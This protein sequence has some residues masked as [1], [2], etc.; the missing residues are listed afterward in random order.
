MPSLTNT[1]ER[2][3]R[4]WGV[5]SLSAF[6]R[7]SAVV[8]AL[9]VLTACGLGMTSA[10]RLDRGQSAFADGD[11]RAAA[12][13]ARSVLQKEP[14]NLSARLLLGRSSL[15]LGDPESARKELERAV[16]LG[17]SRTDVML[18][19]AE[20]SL[21]L[22]DFPAAV[23]EV[24]VNLLTDDADR[25]RGHQ[26]RGD[27]S[28]G[29]GDSEAARAEFSAAL[30][31]DDE[32]P[33][34]MLGVVESYTTEGR[35][36]QARAT[37]EQIRGIHPNQVEVWLESGSLNLMYGTPSAAL[38]DFRQAT[39][40]A[41][42]QNNESA[43]LA[44]LMG[45]VES[46]LLLSN[47]EEAEGVLT[48]LESRVVDASTHL[49][50][51]RLEF[52]RQNWEAAQRSVQ[53]S[54]RIA[55]EFRPAQMLLG[56]THLNRGNL[57]QAE[58][59][60]SAVVAASPDDAD[61]R[62]LLAETQIQL[63]KHDLAN[64]ALRPLIAKGST[65]TRAL[66]AAARASLATGDFAAAQDFMQRRSAANPNDDALSLDL[67]ATYLATGD[68]REAEAL[69]ASIDAGSD[70]D[71]RRREYLLIMA[72]VRSGAYDDAEAAT[73]RL[74]DRWPEDAQFR[75]LLGGIQTSMGDSSAAGQTYQDVL[76]LEPGN[77]AA[78]MSLGDMELAA[79]NF[80]AA[81]G[82][83]ERA[84]AASD[85]SVAPMIALAKTA[86]GSGDAQATEEWLLRARAADPRDA[87]SRLYLGRYYL[88][89]NQLQQAEEVALEAAEIAPLNADVANLLGRVQMASG[90]L[91]E[92]VAALRQAS[93]AQPENSS[94]RFDYVRSLVAARRMDDA[95]SIL[96]ELD[97]ASDS[98]DLMSRVRLAVLRAESGDSEA[99]IREARAL[100]SRYPDN[101]MPWLL[102]G[103][104]LYNFGD[105]RYA[106]A[107][108]ANALAR[109]PDE[110]LAI[111]AY[112]LRQRHGVHDPEEPLRNLLQQRPD[113]TAARLALA[114]A[115]H[116]RSDLDAAIAEYE[117]VLADAPNN[118]VALN[119][120]A[121]AYFATGDGRAEDI[122]RRAFA[123]Y[124]DSDSIMDTLGWILTRSGKL[125]E[126]IGLLRQASEVSGGRGEVAYHLAYALSEQGNGAEAKRILEAALGS[127]ASFNSRDDAEALL[128]TL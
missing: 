54:L 33:E 46:L 16:E 39:G 95:R 91:D 74:V 28:L 26:L 86:G 97:A 4:T 41:D 127:D 90:K 102:E 100:Q 52:S 106:A 35:P 73:R 80:A 117:Q 48:Q 87:L 120:L 103:E 114:Q 81:R 36:D 62:R 21:L 27:A 78:R 10:E 96:D 93:A 49:L 84:L 15:R 18:D 37:L 126:G 82:H 101:P 109:R 110:R 67:A 6:R 76:N 59:Y 111:R 34:A 104:L 119:N 1:S 44:A 125:D 112:G 22:G 50:R 108:Y 85:S 123:E 2:T 60:L 105:A 24:D 14:D 51:G 5:A 40:L 43:E 65:D 25:V 17:Q 61:A 122:A 124:P 116:A 83:F 19:L 3:R 92:G 71:D 75:L 23:N 77:L 13:D 63:Q 68:V 89:T 31:I 20:A 69:L 88:S 58:M 107:A 47:L 29:L 128:A 70:F 66:A 12:I 9:L 53:E 45:Q 56:A 113:A 57:E 38:D 30:R 32:N 79:G 7:L 98:S 72:Q 11:H 42:S 115:F 64:D 99:G 118:V 55:P 8:P 94:F 121:W